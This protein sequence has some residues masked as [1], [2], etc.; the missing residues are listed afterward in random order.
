VPTVLLRLVNAPGFSSD[1]VSSIRA[2]YLSGAPVSEAQLEMLM[3]IL[4]NN[5][6]MRRY[7]LTEMTPVSSTNLDDDIEHILCTVGKPLAGTDVRIIDMATG[8]YCPTGVKG[9]I[10]VNGSNLMCSYY[11]LPV[12]KQ[13][14][15]ENGY[16]HTGDL[17]FL[18]EKGYLHFSGRVKEIII[19]GGE[20]IM[21]NE[22][23]S[24]ISMHNSIADVKV[25]GVPDRILGEAVAAAVVLKEGASFDENEI[26]NFLMTKLARFKI[27][28]YFFI[29]EKLPALANG[30]VDAVSLKKELTEKLEQKG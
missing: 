8:S 9:E 3:K 28:S 30:K 15:D 1:F 7:G 25:I 19:R 10:I 22:V 14:F 18:D 26:R 20:N 23:A 11:K 4:P 29:Y 27:P 12:D 17:G 5:H 16:L 2:S 6:F 13:P 21:P 24:A